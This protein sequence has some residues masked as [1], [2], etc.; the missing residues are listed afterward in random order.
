MSTDTPH[1]LQQPTSESLSD[2]PQILQTIAIL[3]PPE[4]PSSEEWRS[5]S[6]VSVMVFNL[7]HG[8]TTA[9]I[10]R[11]LKAHGNVVSIR[12][13]QSRQGGQTHTAE[14]RFKPPPQEELWRS[15]VRHWYKGSD[16]VPRRIRFELSRHQRRVFTVPSPV[17]AVDFPEEI[18]LRGSGLGFGILGQEMEMVVMKSLTPSSESTLEGSDGKVSLNLNLRKR[19]IEVHFPV[20]LQSKNG[21]RTRGYRFPISFDENFNVWRLNTGN[22]S[23]SYVIHVRNPPWYSRRLETA[24]SASHSKDARSWSEDDLWTR[25]TDIVSHKDLFD[26][27]NQTPISLRKNLNR[28]NIGRWTT[29]K[30]DLN[31]NEQESVNLVLFNQALK[32]F[33]I[34]V[35]E[36]L[37]NF[38]IKTASSNGDGS[39]WSDIEDTG[40][41]RNPLDDGC[42]LSFDLRYQLE[43][44]ISH[45][46]L[47]EY[48]IDK[49][50]LS[51]LKSLPESKAK[52]MLILVDSIGE[53][54]RNPM[55]LFTDIRFQKPVRARQLPK[56]CF[57]VHHATVTATSIKIDTPTVEVSNRVIR[58]HSQY[59]DRF[60]R[61]RFEDDEYRGQTR[62]YASSNKK[63]Q[64]VFD[65]VRRALSSGIVVVGR[66]YEFLA[67]GNSQLREHGAYFF[68]STKGLNASTIRGEMGE[69]DNEKIV[70]KRAARM[71]Q[72]FSTTHPIH[73]RLPPITKDAL[74]PDIVQGKYTFS[75]GVGKVSALAAALI[76]GGL[77]IQGATP[78]CFQF[79]LGG[80]K[81]VLV[82][83]P[84]LSGT[85]VQIR[86]SQYKFESKSQELEIIRYSHF[87]QPFLNRQI[88]LVLNNLGVKDEVF[89]EMQEETIRALNKAMTNDDAA[90]QSLRTHVDPNSITL[91]ICDLVANGFRRVKEPFVMSLLELWRA[92]SLKYL[93]E[94]AKI[95]VKDGAFVL[96]VVDETNTLRGHYDTPE[97]SQG[98]P[99]DRKDIA[100]LPE[101][102]IQINDP[103][104]EKPRVIEGVCI[105]AR[106]PSLHPGDIRVVNAV[107]VPAL[108][109]LYDIVVMPQNGD[110]D[111][112]SMC[113]GGDL[114]GDDYIVI[115]DQR[116]IPE[117]WNAEP[118]H[119]YPPN[120]VKAEGE[121]T[122]RHIIDFFIHY[123][124]NDTLG[125][126]AHAHLGQAD[127]LDLGVYSCEC[128]ELTQL[129]STSVDYPKTGVPAKLPR[130]LEPNN[131]PHYMEKRGRPYLSR[132]VLGQLYD[133]V[134]KKVKRF[135][136]RAR[137][138]Q[139][140]DSRILNIERPGPAIFAAVEDVK[141]EYDM[142]M[143]RIMAQHKIKTEFEVWS[144]FVMSHSKQSRDFKFHEEIGQI[145]KNLKDEYRQ[146]LVRL[147]GGSDFDRL[148]P[149]AVAAYQLTAEQI[150]EAL[151]VSDT[152]A[153]DTH[154]HGLSD[155][156]DEAVNP[157]A[158]RN[159]FCSFPWVL[160]DVLGK[161]AMTS[162]L[163]SSGGD[164]KV[165]EQTNIV[166]ADELEQSRSSKSEARG[167]GENDIKLAGYRPDPK[168]WAHNA[169]PEL[170]K[171]RSSGSNDSCP[172]LFTNL[173]PFNGTARSAEIS[174]KDSSSSSSRRSA[175][176][177][178]DAEPS[179]AL[180]GK[181]PGFR[182][183]STS[184][185]DTKSERGSIYD[186][187]AFS[188][189]GPEYMS[190]DADSFVHLSQ[191][192]SSDEPS[193]ID[194]EPV[195]VNF[196]D[197]TDTSKNWFAP[198]P[199]KIMKTTTLPIRAVK[200]VMKD[201]ALMTD[202]E[203]AALL[204]DD[205]L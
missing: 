194:T 89:L 114:D 30:L 154:E 92:Y 178:P 131:W 36:D 129:H 37:D 6:F 190:S 168:S 9:D 124:M 21:S 133:A 72:C 113:S 40:D 192:V 14:V 111:L 54:I 77:A 63:M 10:H 161:V 121:I 169:S 13:L 16:G 57:L 67:Y 83:D 8:T 199:S 79:R 96:G 84:T 170:K 128:Q 119:Y 130:Q 171:S 71:G 117:T 166:E 31:A 39:Y 28:I 183:Q 138:K 12:I 7:P 172:H 62:L 106:N 122:T 136:F 51:K 186:T 145:S 187:K 110:R 159:P 179:S 93:K 81:G 17:Q 68:S 50:F 135:D 153:T 182:S 173:N 73:C 205:D 176:A 112:P 150:T 147:A 118:F 4:A 107:D 29:F 191:E 132:K 5:Y 116:L 65:R 197:A 123:L 156:E 144:T 198:A 44:C 165:S 74:I 163:D 27:I 88:I 188:R 139:R 32:D 174:S 137:Y 99:D 158:P 87:W 126:I 177:V 24:L 22:G 157:A 20:L 18:T 196:S 25:Q 141:Y 61:I 55:D 11:N 155:D 125:R 140:F 200:G 49:E 41:P 105:L 195:N 162:N 201:P 203:K 104:T 85:T 42:A 2:I 43:V 149:Y 134:K 66:S 184:S 120:P 97:G 15:G 47:S 52:Q 59:A 167:F 34:H 91:S 100:K 180:S 75:D 148:M 76:Q 45:G 185:S 1:P 69:F 82:V 189:Q 103:I 80:C 202:E 78:S 108:R 53:E 109:H 193:P 102:F 3:I 160:A 23:V 115:W 151:E 127:F 64:L 26:A 98:N 19:E 101:I 46:W 181:G 152:S 94:K 60:L 48:S 95:P 58:K 33:N 146:E 90:Q 38:S 204:A 143:A 86:P 56:N 164:N 142:S 35:Q 70:A 175:P